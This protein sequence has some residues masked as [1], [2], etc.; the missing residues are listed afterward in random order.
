MLFIGSA[1]V[2][3]IF[4]RTLVLSIVD[5][6]YLSPFIHLVSSGSKMYIK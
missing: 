3:Y 5:L 2:L 6:T 1:A 4:I